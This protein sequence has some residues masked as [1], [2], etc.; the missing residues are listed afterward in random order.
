MK[1]TV[2]AL[3]GVLA[4]MGA[5]VGCDRSDAPESEPHRRE[6][7]GPDHTSDPTSKPAE[8]TQ[9]AEAIVDVARIRR[10]KAGLK[11]SRPVGVAR[12]HV[13]AIAH[14][15][16]GSTHQTVAGA[17]LAVAVSATGRGCRVAGAR[18]VAYDH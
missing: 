1:A 14:G 4:L 13:V 2:Y 10:L 3:A 15:L 6:A 17:A 16:E 11:W 18:R 9:P 7:D 12:D 8:T 5:F